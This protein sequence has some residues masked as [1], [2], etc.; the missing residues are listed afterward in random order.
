MTASSSCHLS[1]P[2]LVLNRGWVAID[3][4]PVAD[5]LRL[6]ARGAARVIEP[7]T[8]ATHCFES[9][10]DLSA[11]EHEPH[12][13]TVSLRIPIPEV[14]VLTQY[15]G[16]PKRGVT[17][18]R[19]NLFRRDAHTCQ[20]CGVQPGTSEL[21]IDH[22]VPSSRGGKTSWD[23]C[24]LA[25]VDCNRRKADREPHE[26]GMQLRKQPAAPAWSPTLRIPIGR[27]RQAWE[28]FVSE[29][30]WNTPLAEN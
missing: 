11:A 4:T 10:A 18:S 9:W 28:N 5:A 6:L 16:M 8:Y 22:V 19:R 14:I 3:T 2:T 1:Q 13:R 30:Y 12:V 24:V 23:N 21:S 25:C 20:Y 15:A 26:A 17:F 7:E 29:R 27:R